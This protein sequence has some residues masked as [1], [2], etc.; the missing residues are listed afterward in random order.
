ML[1]LNVF[2]SQSS[3]NNKKLSLNIIQVS[4][5]CQKTN[6]TPITC[7]CKLLGL[8]KRICIG[9]LCRHNNLKSRYPSIG[10]E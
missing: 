10:A 6:V 4:E 9:Y 8:G 7:D 3:S 2:P 1:T 5:I